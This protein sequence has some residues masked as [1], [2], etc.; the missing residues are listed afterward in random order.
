MIMIMEGFF[1]EENG[2]FETKEFVILLMCIIMLPT[3]F[4]WVVP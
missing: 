4:G 2:N 3:D 1:N